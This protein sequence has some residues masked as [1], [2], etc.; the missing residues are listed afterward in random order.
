MGKSKKEKLIPLSRITPQ[1]DDMDTVSSSKQFGDR[2]AFNILMEAQQYWDSMSQ[3]RKDRERN[4]RYMYGDQWKDVIQV[5]HKSM[6]EEDYIK[7]QGS[8]PLKNNLIR[9]LATSVLGVYRSQSKEPVC[10]ARDRQEQ[11]LGETMTVTL[12]YNRDLNNMGE[13]D[14]RMMEEFLTS[15]SAIQRFSAGWRN[16]KFDCWTDNVNPNM[17][18]VDNCMRDFRAWDCSMCGEV[19]DISFGD[20]VSVFAHNKQDYN[21]LANIYS[22]QH[23]H[24]KHY[25]A[26][27]CN[28]FGYSDVRNYDFLFTSDTSRCR[29]IEVWRKE[30]KPRIFCHDP[31][32]GDYYKIDLEDEY[33]MVDLV[34]EDRIRRGLEAGMEEDEIPLI[35]KE[36][37][38]DQYWYY[39]FLTPFGD[40]LDEGETPYAHGEHPYVFKFYPYLDGEVHS[41]VAD[42]IDQQRYVNR[43]VTLY[44]WIMRASAKGVLL[45]P[46]ECKP[47]D[48]SMEEIADEWTRFNGLIVFKSK[49]NA[50]LPQQIANNSTNIGISELLNLQIK[51]FEDITGVN[52]ALQGKPGYSGM[53]A[54]LYSQQTQNATITLLDILESFSSFIKAGALK[55]VK[56]IQQFYDDVRVFNIT[57]KR[58][59]NTVYDPKK[60]RDVEMDVNISES[61]STPVYRQ[62][63]N[64]FLM[65]I[66][67]AGQISIQ[68]LLECGSFPF[69]DQLLQSLQAQQEQIA[70]GQTPEGLP[71]QLLQQIQQGAN[72]DSVNRTANMLGRPQNAA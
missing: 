17:F 21:R 42:V 7:S 59:A 20:L 61:T 28:R 16:N 57:G 54:S 9:R 46:E 41:F 70:K 35:T 64:D 65:E 44:D 62:L 40:I 53:S 4:K 39:Y 33:E 56:N 52:G 47:D 24:N 63:G 27:V 55:Q 31:N 3:F 5:D 6:T 49:N 71:P 11:T 2:R 1:H 10:T 37:K 25:V 12:K 18:F 67:R 29:V 68:Q 72:M 26:T 69:A 50:H 13:G 34:N 66:W 48:M 38:V 30:S 36:W 43:L 51:F 8:I 60:I 23:A 32:N 15:A 14:A 45:F 58:G 19:H 22:T